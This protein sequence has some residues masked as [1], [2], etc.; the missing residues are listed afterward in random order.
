MSGLLLSILLMLGGALPAGA[1]S[2]EAAS[3]TVIVGKPTCGSCRVELVRVTS[4]DDRDANFD[5]IGLR[6]FHLSKGRLLLTGEQRSS[7]LVVDTTGRRLAQ[8]G[9]RGGGPGE[10]QDINWVIESPAGIVHVFDYA[11]RR[12]SDLESASLRLLGTSEFPAVNEAIPLSSGLF[13][14]SGGVTGDGATGQP[15][16][17]VERDGRIRSSFGAGSPEY[18]RATAGRGLYRLLARGRD[19]GIWAAS[20]HSYALEKWTPGAQRTALIRRE[21]EWFEEGRL[22]R[23]IGDPARDRPPSHIRGI[24]EDHDGL[25]WVNIGVPAASWKPAASPPRSGEFSPI[26]E[27]EF[28]RLFDTIIEVYDPR[29]STLLASQRIEGFVAPISGG[30]L[31]FTLGESPDGDRLV[32]VLRARL[33]R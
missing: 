28:R 10:Y 13:F 16:H 8:L 29:S 26:S 25:L 24:W 31:Q 4:F 9:R 22:E 21:V 18:R 19:G 6:V 7:L 17:L 5:A 33:R 1:Q 30:P 2:R 32:T 23:G 15:L 12:R 11:Q 20:L 3:Q 14:A 27:S